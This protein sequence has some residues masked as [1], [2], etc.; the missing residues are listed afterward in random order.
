MGRITPPHLALALDRVKAF[1]S[2]HPNGVDVSD[3]LKVEAYTFL[4]KKARE[5]LLDVIERYN[6]L[7]VVR[8]GKPGREN[9]WLRHKRYEPE[10][11]DECT[12]KGS[13]ELHYEISNRPAENAATLLSDVKHK[14]NE[15]METNTKRTL[16]PLE[17][18]KQ[19][20]DLLR[21]AEDAERSLT[22]KDIFQKQLDPVRREVLLAHTKLTKGFET[23]VDGMA[24]LDTA[25][26]KFRD[27]KIAP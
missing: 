1:V 9:I 20:E 22:A 10:H 23:M 26:A 11:I 18:R 21:Q 24:E 3:L 7:V 8:S 2:K 12:E 19:A 25:I 15:V 17:L 14:E 4:N 27:F 13:K 6:Q 5:Q 16:S